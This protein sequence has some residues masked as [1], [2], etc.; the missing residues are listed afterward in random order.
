MVETF[1]KK[2]Y[3]GSTPFSLSA[4]QNSLVEP[5]EESLFEPSLGC[6]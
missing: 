6:G 3:G 1:M 2:Y 4:L 5:C